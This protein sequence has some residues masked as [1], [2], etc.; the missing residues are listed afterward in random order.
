MST[1]VN[2]AMAFFETCESGKG[3]EQCQQYCHDDAIFNVHA[4]SLEHYKTV[5]EYSE[6]LPHLMKI[7]PDAHYK[8]INVAVDEERETVIV[9]ARFYGT[10]TGIDEPVPATGK[11]LATNYGF[12]MRLQDGKVAEVTKVWNDGHAH[13]QLGWA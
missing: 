2:T 8:L 6:S 13:V 7:L 11:S 3:W 10:H 12:V 5:A 1:L 9:F 4:T